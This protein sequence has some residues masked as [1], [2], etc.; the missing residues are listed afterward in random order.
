DHGARVGVE[1]GL[2]LAGNGRRRFGGGMIPA[3]PS[4]QRYDFHGTLPLLHWHHAN[5]RAMFVCALIIA[6]PILTSRS[7]S[8]F[9]PTLCAVTRAL[10]SSRNISSASISGS[11]RAAAAHS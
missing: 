5:E 11:A 4:V 8:P 3:Q 7:P 6:S 2:I 1:E 10:R 9:G